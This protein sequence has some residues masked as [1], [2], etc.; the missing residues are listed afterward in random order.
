MGLGRHP[1]GRVGQVGAQSSA[2]GLGLSLC[3]VHPSPQLWD[4][5]RD[6]RNTPE[7]TNASWLALASAVK[8]KDYNTSHSLSWWEREGQMS[9]ILGN[10]MHVGPG[11][12]RYSDQR[13]TDVNLLHS[14][15]VQ[16]FI[17]SWYHCKGREELTQPHL[18]DAQPRPGVGHCNFTCQT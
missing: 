6:S 1:C 2:R 9:Q 12:A 5:W 14:L 15:C 8:L 4:H 3:H 11:S 17:V 18:T 10:K 16:E 13:L 7:T